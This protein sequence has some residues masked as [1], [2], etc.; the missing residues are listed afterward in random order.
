[1]RIGRLQIIA[2]RWPWQDGYCWRGSLTLAALN[3]PRP[4]HRAAPRFGGGWSYELGFRAG[5]R[6][7]NLSLLFGVVSLSWLRRTHC[8]DCDA[9]VDAFHKP[10]CPH[11]HADRPTAWL[12]RV[13]GL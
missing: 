4:G 7:V 1:M 9:E 11:F 2:R 5:G 8:E 6:T 12:N 3:M 10:A 13:R